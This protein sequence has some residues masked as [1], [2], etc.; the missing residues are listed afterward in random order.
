MGSVGNTR[1]IRFL[2]G[3]GVAALLNL[4]LIAVLIEYLGFNT[5]WLRSVANVI[6]IELSLL[7]SFVIYRKWVWPGGSWSLK[8]ILLRQLPLYHM[9]AGL[10]VLSRSL[11]VFPL[12]DRLGVSYGV[13]TLLGALLSAGINY[14]I[15]DRL[16]FK[17]SQGEPALYPPEGLTAANQDYSPSS[18]QTNPQQT[19]YS[20]MSLQLS[21]V[22]PAYNEEGCIA[23][24]LA[25]IST[26]L[27]QH[28][29][30]YDILVVN[31]NSRDS[32]EDILQQISYQNAR[33]RYINN[34]YPNGFGFAVR[35]GLENFQ[36]DAVTVVMADASDPPE[37][38]VDYYQ[39][40][41]QGF[42]CVFGSRF[43]RGGKVYDYPRHKLLINRLANL[44]V[45]VLFN[46]NYNDTTNAF[47]AY[48]REVIE[49]IS[50]LVSHHFNLTVEMPLKAMIRG[51]SPAIV[52]IRWYN[53]QTGV[54][55]LKIKEMGSRY[56]FIVLYLFAE[57]MLSQ[58][59]YVKKERL[60]TSRLSEG[61]LR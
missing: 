36:G 26:Y 46:L 9:A 55:K 59:D 18:Q 5:T 56:L 39:K 13:N 61:A 15:S 33:V 17:D 21:I 22:I 12:L 35:C 53:R 52:P 38:I 20:Q 7:F 51:Y 8:N 28:K 42:D 49:D 14:A 37:C 1:G 32:T 54:S 31:D 19:D 57:K 25:G 3:G 16:V 40:L 44:F 4:I 34:Y 23:S 45:K 10:A 47:K 60:E 43:V 11:I 58:G 50:P 24:T 6:A 30:N 29:I 2:I 48:R 27:D 41:T